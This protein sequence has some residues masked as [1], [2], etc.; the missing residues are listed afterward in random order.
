MIE[1]LVVCVA[2]IS[3]YFVYKILSLFFNIQ[4]IDEIAEVHLSSV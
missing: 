1:G 2:I 4:Y 3:K